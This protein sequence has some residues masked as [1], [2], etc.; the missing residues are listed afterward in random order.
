MVKTK[1]VYIVVELEDNLTPCETISHDAYTNINDA[2]FA[3]EQ[4]AAA[5][6]DRTFIVLIAGIKK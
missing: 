2:N 1:Y 4:Y 5:N 3:R 6:P